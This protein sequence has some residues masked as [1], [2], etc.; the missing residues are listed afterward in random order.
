MSSGEGALLAQ[1]WYSLISL[2]I[3]IVDHC[4]ISIASLGFKV[5]WPTMI[6]CCDWEPVLA[7]LDQNLP[8]FK[9][10]LLPSFRKMGSLE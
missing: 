10:K 7:Y 2:E 8:N 3:G 5:H 4:P 1:M 6:L 9:I